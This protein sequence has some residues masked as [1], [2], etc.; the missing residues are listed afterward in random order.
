M[1]FIKIG[2]ITTTHGIKGELKIK[3]TNF[4]KDSLEGIESFYLGDNKVKLSVE[5]M[6][7]H[8]DIFITKFKEY[9]NIND[10]LAYKDFE[11]FIDE[12]DRKPLGDNEYFIDDLIGINVYNMNNDFIG[13]I[14]EVMQGISNDVYVITNKEKNAEY[15]IP[16]VGEFVKDIDVE[17]KK[18]IIDPIDGMIE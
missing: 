14:K 5:K 2:K 9:D 17:N 13:E 1:E 6:R 12:K 10:V 7:E 3:S 16:V 15:L 11:V 18:I 4:D 8:K